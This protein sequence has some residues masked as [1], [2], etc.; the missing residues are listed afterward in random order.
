MRHFVLLCPLFLALGLAAQ[1]APEITTQQLPDG[2][3]GEDYDVYLRAQGGTQPLQWQVV[4]GSLP[5]GI[6]LSYGRIVGEPTVPGESRFTLR[7]TDSAKP[8]HTADR[9]LTL[10][11]RA[12]LEVRWEQQPTVVDGEIHGSVTVT[13]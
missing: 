10:R 4:K 3:P 12:A 1:S 5:A 13:N 8:P 11:I 2:A 7:V 6:T 9:E